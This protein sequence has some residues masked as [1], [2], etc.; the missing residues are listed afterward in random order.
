[1]TTKIDVRAVRDFLKEYQ[2]RV[3]NA[4]TQEDGRQTFQTD[5]WQRPEG[6]GG[7]TCI[8]S[9]GAV[10]EQAGVGFS[11]VSGSQLPASATAQRP[12]LAGRTYEA[13]GVSIVIHPRNPYVPTS[14]ANVRFFIAH[15]QSEAPIWWFGGGFDLTPYYGF[16]EDARHWHTVARDACAPFGDEVY[17]RYKKW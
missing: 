15:H 3:V 16:E 11:H 13:M 1:M 2:D 9:G 5:V 14:H 10:F 8:L 7:C 4:I 17:P 6:G 12:Q